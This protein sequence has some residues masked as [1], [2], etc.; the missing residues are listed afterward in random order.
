MKYMK[1]IAL[2]A[3][4]LILQPVY[5]SNRGQM[6]KVAKAAWKGAKVTFHT[7][8]IIGGA[9]ALF[10]TGVIGVDILEKLREGDRSAK[11]LGD[12]PLCD[13]NLLIFPAAIATGSLLNSCIK[14]LNQEQELSKRAKKIV[15]YLKGKRK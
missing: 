3:S 13:G 2:L 15:N 11:I 1:L 8:E 4:T 6:E 14:G 12:G 5:A 9:I 10:F 7:G